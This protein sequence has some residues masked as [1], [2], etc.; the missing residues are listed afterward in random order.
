MAQT[1]NTWIIS[2][3]KSEQYYAISLDST[4]DLLHVD[5]LAFTIRYVQDNGTDCER[6]VQFVKVSSHTSKQL[7]STVKSILMDLTLDIADCRGLSTDN[8]SNMYRLYN[9]LEQRLE[10]TNSSINFVHCAAHSLNLVGVSSVEWCCDTVH[11][12][13]FLK[14]VQFFWSST[15]RWEVLTNKLS[16][17]I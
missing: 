8:A 7:T 5:Q 12:F 11:F 15:H 6:F 17:D 9:G 3:I 16:N 1:V 13:V 14:T 10:D 4:S 2:E